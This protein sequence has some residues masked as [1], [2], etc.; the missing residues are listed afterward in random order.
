MTNVVSHIGG[1]KVLKVFTLLSFF[2]IFFSQAQHRQ[3]ALSTV[4]EIEGFNRI[5]QEKIFIHYTSTLAFAGEYLHYKIYCINEENGKLSSISKI[6]YIRLINE[7]GESIIKHKIVLRDGTGE[8][9]V[10]IPVSI[11]SGSYKIIGYTQWML[12]VSESYFFAG[13]VS[14]LNPYQGNQQKILP[15]AIEA[16]SL[17]TKTE[18][19]ESRIV[20]SSVNNL[21]SISLTTKEFNKRSMVGIKVKN[22]TSALGDYSISVRKVNEITS[23]PLLNTTNFVNTYRQQSTTSKKFSRKS[24]FLPEM[25]GE[26]VYGKILSNNSSLPV[27]NIDVGFSIPESPHGIY[28]VSTDDE[29]SFVFSLD[30]NFEKRKGTVQIL[31]K[32][33]EQYQLQLEDMPEVNTKNLDMY[34]FAITPEVKKEIVKRSIYNQIEHSF[35]NLKPDTLKQIK[36]TLPFYGKFFEKYD[37]DDY[38]R[39]S[40]IRE[41]IVEIIDRVRTRKTKDKKEV[42]AI[43]GDYAEKKDDKLLPL[44]LVDNTIVQEHEDIINYDARKVK[45]I[46]FITNVYYLGTKRYDGVIYVETLNNDFHEGYE[47][48]YIKPITLEQPKERKSYYKQNYLIENDYDRIPDYRYQLLWQPKITLEAKEE[49][50]IDFFTSDATGEFEISLEGFTSDGEPISLR[51]YFTVK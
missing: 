34:K 26:L 49:Q 13:D 25:R 24:V 37:L 7:K 45:S 28:V 39:F 8:G 33:K 31:D 18:S 22:E 47:K 21:V 15:D 11:P 30:N 36:K 35:Y 5:P 10:F 4:K 38:T 50:Q 1:N 12:N 19:E 16:D 43:Q 9:D 3:T 14:I 23:S 44:L 2:S 51:K 48:S 27:S 20:E 42:F 41:T 6:A 46:G 17:N 40:T 32:N 29:G